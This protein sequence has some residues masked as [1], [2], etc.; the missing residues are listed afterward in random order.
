MTPTVTVPALEI[1]PAWRIVADPA[2]LDAAAWPAGTLAMRLAPDDVLLFD[3]HPPAIADPYA[4]VEPDHGW[5]LATL[6]PAELD[7]VSHHVEWAL[8]DGLGQGLVAGVPAKLVVSG[9][10]AVL[11]TPAAYVGEL[12]RRLGWPA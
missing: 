9:G 8:A 5:S 2:A 7:H 10:G 6:G 12:A 3:G 11:V 1:R 4:I